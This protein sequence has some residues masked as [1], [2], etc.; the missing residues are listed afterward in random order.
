[1]KKFIFPFLSHN[2]FVGGFMFKRLLLAVL[3]ISSIFIGYSCFNNPSDDDDD[4]ITVTD[5]SIDSL[6]AILVTRVNSLENVEEYDDF[7]A[8]EF[9]DLSDAFTSIL[10]TKPNHVKVNTGY[11]VSTILALNK[12]ANLKKLADSLD[13]FFT[14][15][16]TTR[17]ETSAFRSN[18]MSN[19]L[20][21]SRLF[22][23]NPQSHLLKNSLDKHGVNGLGVALAARS[24]E[25]VAVQ[26][27]DPTFPGFLSMSFIQNIAQN[28]IIPVLDNVIQAFE[29]LEALADM[30][31]VFTIDNEEV[32]IDLGDINIVDAGIRLLRAQLLMMCTYDT[33]MFTSA[34]DKTYS[35]IDDMIDADDASIVKNVYT[36]SNDTVTKTRIMD[37]SQMML[38]M[39]DVWKY[40]MADRTSYM[41]IKTANHAKAYTDYKK[42]PD[43]IKTGLTIIKNESDDQNNDL[44]PKVDIDD[45]SGEMVDIQQEMLD[46]GFSTAFAENFKSPEALMDFIKTL[47]TSPYTV[48]E[49]IDSVTVTITI[50]ISKFFTNPVSDLKTL[51]P[52]HKFRA[53]ADRIEGY[54]EETDVVEN[55]N[56]SYFTMYKDE[57]EVNVIAFDSSLIDSIVE[58]DW[59]SLVYLQTPV[60]YI[61]HLD[62]SVY[63]IPLDM[64]DD[65]N[66]VIPFDTIPDLIDAE[67]FL[68]YFNDYTFNGIFPAM[69]RQK[70]LDLIYQ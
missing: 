16:D 67:T 39:C 66:T 46:E 5:K 15:I 23:A 19:G 7:Y 21:S 12:N 25:I 65:A 63:A 35:W 57:G 31:L 36:L 11:I 10:T 29:R 6:F 40:N 69:T 4:P 49:T 50:D 48:N 18:P 14:G 41:T 42:A 44:I 9:K 34:G 60:R 20:I 58:N 2:P 47:L 37:D 8:M 68:P 33:D 38:I 70:W 54:C 45:I 1:M 26:T 27:A 24:P 17:T 32:E 53:T 3:L 22:K 30:S 13:A 55:W 43:L 61:R 64:V 59:E 62:S 52:K 28:E 51:L 56:T